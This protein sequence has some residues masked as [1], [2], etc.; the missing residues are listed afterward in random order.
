MLAQLTSWMALGIIADKT[1]TSTRVPHNTYTCRQSPMVQ[2][3]VLLVDYGKLASALFGNLIAIATENMHLTVKLSH[4]QWHPQDI[5]PPGDGLAAPTS[6]LARLM[7]WHRHG[8]WQAVRSLK[9]SRLKCALG[10][11]QTGGAKG[12]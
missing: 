1:A 3:K 9:I 5:A 12:L 6:T 10:A 2:H 11:V 7:T 4:W 8:T